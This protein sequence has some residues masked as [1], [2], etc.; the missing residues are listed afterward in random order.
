[1]APFVQHELRSALIALLP[2]LR[3]FGIA[4]TGSAADADELVQAACERAVSRLVQLRTEARLDSW[5]F[6]I[7][8][9]MWADEVRARRLR[10]HEPVEAASET[11]GE[12]GRAV[13]EARLTLAAVREA[14]ASLPEEQ[15]AVLMLVCVDG[16]S[17][18]EAAEALGI[19]CGTVM[20]RLA[21][22]RRALHRK[23]ERQGGGDGVVIPFGRRR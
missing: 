8:R 18:K 15:R 10:R 19:P 14:L 22:G 6:R 9:N 11:A 23:L 13:L 4:L 7:M 20:S 16:L 17:Y 5:I 21:R 3:R 1:L 2:R 12:D